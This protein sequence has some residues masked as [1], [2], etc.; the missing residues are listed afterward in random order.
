LTVRW[1]LTTLPE[2]LRVKTIV[3]LLPVP[4][5][6]LLI[7]AG[8]S[9]RGVP[10]DGIIK[11][12]NRT[13]G[14]FSAL[15]AEGAYKV[16]WTAGKPALTIS[17]DQNLLPLITTEV[18]GGTLRIRSDQPLSPTREITV[19]VSGAGLTAVRLNGHVHFAAHEI[20]GDNFKLESAGAT[21]INL[22]G[23]VAN[24]EGM[25]TGASHVSAKSLKTK[26]SRLSLLGA[27]DAHVSVSDALKVSIMGAGSVTYSGNPSSVEKKI[28]GQG[29]VKQAP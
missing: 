6:A 28:T 12:E 26:T 10:G 21:D 9:R 8:C 27:T 5:L 13:I 24:F 14:D 16:V 17:A 4:L 18:S 7:I 23:T 11:T 20:S 3:K 15:S 19:T 22:D 29:S 2:T 25:L 1:R